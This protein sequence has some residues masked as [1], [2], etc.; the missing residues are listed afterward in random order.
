[1]SEKTKHIVGFSGW[2]DSQACARWVLN[3]FQ[4]ED[5][6][7]TNSDAGKWEDPLTVQ[8]I[9]WYS[10]EIHPVI[11]CNAL[12]KDIWKTPGFAETKG[13]DGDAELTFVEM[14]RIKGRAP[15]RKAQFCTENLK[16][17]PQKRW[18]ENTFGP[19]GEFDGWSYCRYTGVRRDESEARKNAPIHTWDDWFDCELYY[20]IADWTKQM[21]FDYV[22]A[23]GEKV[24][25]L[26]ALGFNRVGCAP[27]INSGKDDIL[28]WEIRRPEMIEKV[29]ELERVTGRTFFSLCV[30]G[31]HTN[32][33]DDVLEWA[34]TSRG[35]RQQPFPIF[36]EREACESKYGLC[37]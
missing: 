18:I 11:K 3:R 24:N 14:V 1:V 28:N 17:Q 33:M 32:S 26:Y 27:C 12:I 31:M 9:E 29:R 36:H 5:V 22:M 8:F 15:S 16:L 7:L 20:P 4:K 2:I 30:P 19:G 25:P 37:E 34:K 10:S 13:L 6:I 21:C 23:Q 35:G